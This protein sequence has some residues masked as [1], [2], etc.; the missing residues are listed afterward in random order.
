MYYSRF[1]LQN[2]FEGV[3]T[4]IRWFSDIGIK[5]SGTR[6]EKVRDNIINYLEKGKDPLQVLNPDTKLLPLFYTIQDSHAFT[7]IQTGFSSLNPNHLPK[8][9]LKDLLA[10]PDFISEEIPGSANVNARNIQ[11]ELEMAAN[12]II[13]GFYV[14]NFEDIIFEAFGHRVAVQCKRPLSRKQV[15]NNIEKA[16]SQ[17]NENN[18]LH[19]S[20]NKGFIAISVEKL[21]NLDEDIIILQNINDLQEHLNKKAREFYNNYHSCWKLFMNK[22]LIG[23]LL[24]FHCMVFE[25]PSKSFTSSFVIAGIRVFEQRLINIMNN[26]IYE[27]VISKLRMG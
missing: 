23:I 19:E 20:L 2:L 9:K 6:I 18:L 1:G 14:N 24:V 4:A 22:N 13:S 8:Q 26:S 3:Q 25:K 27:E 11:F 5:T 7:T 10:G 17:L 12:L 15:R 16:Y 21:F